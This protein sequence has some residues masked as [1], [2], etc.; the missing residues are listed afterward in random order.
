MKNSR[1]D[2]LT[3]V[4]QNLPTAAST[5][6]NKPAGTVTTSDG[7]QVTLGRRGGNFK[8]LS[9]PQRGMNLKL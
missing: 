1:N 2:N 3:D 9:S 7:T 8:P 4:V 5:G 6:G